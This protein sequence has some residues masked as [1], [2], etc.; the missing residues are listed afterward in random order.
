MD[1]TFLNFSLSA[2]FRTP[3]QPRLRVSHLGGCHQVRGCPEVQGQE[4]VGPSASNQDCFPANESS[5]V[6]LGQEFNRFEP[7]PSFPV[8]GMFIE[9]VIGQKTLKI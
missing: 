9:S 6:F 7:M 8:G 4:P 3:G 1:E 5:A 2:G